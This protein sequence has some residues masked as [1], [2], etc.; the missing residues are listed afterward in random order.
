MVLHLPLGSAAGNYRDSY[1]SRTRSVTQAAI[2][3]ISTTA[4]PVSRRTPLSLVI[5]GFANIEPGERQKFLIFPV[6]SVAHM[7][8]ASVLLA[9]LQYL[10]YFRSTSIT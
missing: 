7:A 4:F 10:V 3:G 6:R 1:R 2:L 8:L 5:P 9:I